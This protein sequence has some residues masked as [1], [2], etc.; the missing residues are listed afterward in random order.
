MHDSFLRARMTNVLRHSRAAAAAP[1]SPE[2]IA[3]STLRHRWHLATR[4]RLTGCAA[5]IYGGLLGEGYS[6]SKITL[7]WAK[8]RTA[9]TMKA[10]KAWPLEHDSERL[11]VRDKYHAKTKVQP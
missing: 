6:P 2:A 7:G 4:E 8:R 3:S 1:W 10:G 5:R 9:S 11:R